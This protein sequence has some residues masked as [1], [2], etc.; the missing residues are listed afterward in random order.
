MSQIPLAMSN[1]L[2]ILSR[3][4]LLHT[5]LQPLVRNITTMCAQP[6]ITAYLVG[7]PNGEFFF[8]LLLPM[9]HSSV[10]ILLK[11][12]YKNWVRMKASHNPCTTIFLSPLFS[13]PPS[14]LVGT[15]ISVTLEELGIPYKVREL[16]FSAN[17]Q[18]SDWFL[19]VNPNGRI[20]AITDHSRNN[21]NV[22]E[23]GA[24]MLY[25]VEVSIIGNGTRNIKF[26]IRSDSLDFKHA[27]IA[28][29]PGEQIVAK[30]L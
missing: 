25:L 2:C 18:K 10:D 16:A 14:H 21:F 17:E 1:L 6:D 11:G 26:C 28:L 9:D 4:T 24:I 13:L 23:S 3:I 30:R 7:T 20:P 8:L 27:S 15:K 29:R 5:H 19:K 22:F 12:R